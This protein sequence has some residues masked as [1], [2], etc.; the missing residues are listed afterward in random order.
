[1]YYIKITFLQL[2]EKK[3]SHQGLNPGTSI[4]NVYY[5]YVPIK[6][7]IP[8]NRQA[9]FCSENLDKT[10]SLSYRHLKSY[11]SGLLCYLH[12]KSDVIP[13][14]FLGEKVPVGLPFCISKLVKR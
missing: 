4:Y 5:K 9:H 1:M 3:C 8:T 12:D 2:S 14:V 10:Y 13:K 11:L 7:S 6:L